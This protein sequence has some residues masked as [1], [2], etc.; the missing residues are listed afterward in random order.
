MEV[1][2]IT[3]GGK[4]PV[5]SNCDVIETSLTSDAL[6][7]GYIYEYTVTPRSNVAGAQ[8]GTDSTIT[9]ESSLPMVLH[10]ICFYFNSL[11]LF[12]NFI[13]CVEEFMDLQSSGNTFT[14]VDQLVE[15]KLHFNHADTRKQNVH[16]KVIILL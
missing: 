9:G 15:T 3:C 13:T 4:E 1:Y 11:I 7:S 8:N 5:I 6:Q 2:N 14:S 16:A 12:I 10:V